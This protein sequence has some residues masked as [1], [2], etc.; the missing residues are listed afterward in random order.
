MLKHNKKQTAVKKYNMS[1]E[2]FNNI[3]NRLL[4]KSKRLARF[5]L[6]FGCLSIICSMP[7]LSGIA[8]I[9]VM[10]SWLGSTLAMVITAVIGADAEKEYYSNKDQKPLILNSIS[11]EENAD[12]HLQTTSIVSKR[13][14]F[15]ETTKQTSNFADENN[16]E[17]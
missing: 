2:E 11:D 16:L 5:V 8:A 10:S 12:F 13:E 6:G 17:M 15:K 4:K 9:T 7:F 14:K 3:Q 1:I